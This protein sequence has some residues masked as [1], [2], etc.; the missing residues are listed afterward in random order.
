VA[1]S[2]KLKS[3]SVRLTYQTFISD[4]D[5][6]GREARTL[7][8][9]IKCNDEIQDWICYP[10]V[11]EPT[12]NLELLEQLTAGDQGP[13]PYVG[14]MMRRYFRRHPEGWADLMKA[15]KGTIPHDSL[16]RGNR[17]GAEPENEADIG[18]KA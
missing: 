18:A 4:Y 9:V 14:R 8:I 10:I 5:R 2:K 15:L 17:N 1:K 6:F 12:E 13:M 3:F 16:G 7:H 11:E